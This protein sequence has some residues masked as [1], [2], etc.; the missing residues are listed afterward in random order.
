[1]KIYLLSHPTRMSPGFLFQFCMCPLH[2]CLPFMASISI[3]VI[4]LPQGA[5]AFFVWSISKTEVLGSLCPPWGSLWPR[6]DG[7]PAP[8]L[9]SG[10]TL[11]YGLHSPEGPPPM[12]DQA[13]D[14]LSVFVFR[15]GQRALLLYILLST[16]Q[17]LKQF[18]SFW[19]WADW[20][21]VY[22]F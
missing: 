13:K 10:T 12:G 8:L 19:I 1:M 5:R 18:S 20:V 16:H 11:R 2:C 22:N 21:I 7:C 6:M 14:S 9:V 4:V 15:D 3:S 17:G